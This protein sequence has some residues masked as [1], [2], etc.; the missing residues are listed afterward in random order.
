MFALSSLLDCTLMQLLLS[1]TTVDVAVGMAALNPSSTVDLL[2]LWSP[3]FAL[4]T[5]C[6]SDPELSAMQLVGDMMNK[7]T[8][9]RTALMLPAM[10]YAHLVLHDVVNVKGETHTQSA[11]LQK[12]PMLMKSL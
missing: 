7:K 9:P 12:Q 5:H 10:V 2:H 11:K 4:H 1:C 3:F 8:A 6:W